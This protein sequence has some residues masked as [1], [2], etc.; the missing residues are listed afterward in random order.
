MYIS[1]TLSFI[2]NAK[3]RQCLVEYSINT[4]MKYLRHTSLDEN[5]FYTY[6]LCSENKSGK[7]NFEFAIFVI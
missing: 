2:A 3:Q 5:I 4:Q 7:I 6:Y 1:H